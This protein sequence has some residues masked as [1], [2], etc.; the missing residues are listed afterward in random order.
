MPFNKTTDYPNTSGRHDLSHPHGRAQHNKPQRKWS[1]RK[2]GGG[3]EGE[4]GGGGGG[5]VGGWV[6][7]GRR[8][9][10]PVPPGAVGACSLAARH[11]SSNKTGAALNQGVPLRPR[12]GP[13]TRHERRH[14]RHKWG[15]R[16][17]TCWL[18]CVVCVVLCV[19]Y[20]LLGMMFW[21]GG[22][23]GQM[24]FFALHIRYHGGRILLVVSPPAQDN[25]VSTRGALST[26]E[27]ECILSVTS[28]KKPRQGLRQRVKGRKTNEAK[29]VYLPL[30]P[31][32]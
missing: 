10:H 5:R 17:R 23:F 28:Q 32:L 20:G 26:Y 25:Y 9:H 27:L 30:H 16:F 7:F 4:R 3:G 13:P 19:L 8:L 12:T 2:Q 1:Q 11:G 6:G 21:L 24:F 18:W 29:G 14:L 22:M 15:L 31:D